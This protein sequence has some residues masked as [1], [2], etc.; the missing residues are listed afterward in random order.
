MR[1]SRRPL[2][3][4]TRGLRIEHLLVHLLAKPAELDRNDRKWILSRNHADG[5]G[6]LHPLAVH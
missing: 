3:H 6:T 4:H 1:F 2:Q 5:I